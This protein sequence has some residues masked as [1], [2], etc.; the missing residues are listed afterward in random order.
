MIHIFSKSA[1]VRIALLASI[2]ITFT[3]VFALHTSTQSPVSNITPC[4][5]GQVASITS[6]GLACIAVPFWTGTTTQVSTTLSVR[7]PSFFYT[8]DARQKEGIVRLENVLDRVA[9]LRGYM[10]TFIPTGEDSI[11]LVAQEVEEVFPEIVSEGS[12]GY[13]SVDYGSMVA[14]LLEAVNEQQERIDAL[15]EEVAD[16]RNELESRS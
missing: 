4:T 5:S 3:A 10:F 14:V 7:A 16:L 12:D 11:G 15:R 2:V 1:V 9:R 8:S 13:K 6:N